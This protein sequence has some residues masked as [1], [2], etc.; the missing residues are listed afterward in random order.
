MSLCIQSVNVS[1]PP[2]PVVA[3][4]VL[5]PEHSPQRF[6]ATAA[7]ILSSNCLVHVRDD[8]QLI[9]A[10]AWLGL[11]A[12]GLVRA[13]AVP[14]QLCEVET[15]GTW[16]GFS[17][18][19]P[20]GAVVLGLDGQPATAVPGSATVWQQIGTAISGSKLSLNL[21]PVIELA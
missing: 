15:G 13:S 5:D 4:H 11:A 17:A 20:G 14:G 10:D 12:H 7:M 21:G 6:K 19:A 2:P 16:G 8:G 18:L 3:V 9:R 1:M